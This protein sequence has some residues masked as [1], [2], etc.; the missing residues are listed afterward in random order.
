MPVGNGKHEPSKGRRPASCGGHPQSP[1]TGRRASSSRVG[2]LDQQPLSPLPASSPKRLQH[3]RDTARESRIAIWTHRRRPTHDNPL[4]AGNGGSRH[5]PVNMSPLGQ[6]GS[7]LGNMGPFGKIGSHWESYG[8]HL[9]SCGSHLGN[10][11]KRG[12][13]QGGNGVRS[14]LPSLHL[15]GPPYHPEAL[16]RNRETWLSASRLDALSMLDADTN[17]LGCPRA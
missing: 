8:S 14:A 7:H 4:S 2:A 11:V 3:D 9:R 12:Y 16:F 15:R 1:G 13:V 10:V 6:I 17:K 5:V